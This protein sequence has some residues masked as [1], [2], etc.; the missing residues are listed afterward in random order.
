MLRLT[1]FTRSFGVMLLLSL[2]GVFGCGGGR[3]PADI[4]EGVWAGS[5]KGDSSST[6]L[7]DLRGTPPD[8]LVGT[9][10]V[11]RGRAMDSELAITRASYHAPDL[12]MFIASTNV[13]Y[14]GRV[15]TSR[16]RVEG[17]LMY[18][19]Q[20]GPDMELR[21][22]DPARIPGFAALPGDAP[23]VY[24]EPTDSL[25]EWQTATPEDAG[26]NRSAVEA[27]VNAVAHD[28][29]GLIHSL[30]IV[31]HGKLVLDEYFH[32]YGPDYRHRLASTTK[33][34]ASLLVGA[35]ID[36]GLIAGVDAP[37]LQLL[38][39]PA[40]AAGS[41]WSKE[42]LGDL[43]TMTMG[44]DWTTQE[45]DNTHG[46]GP[47][48]FQKVLA[49]K[50]VKTPGT[51]W[52]YV[53]A[54]VDL[55]AGVIFNATG[56]HAEAFAQEALFSPLGIPTYDWEYGKIDGYNLLDGSLSLRPRD[57]AKIGAMVAAGGRWDGQQVISE[58]WIKESTRTRIA[59]GQPVLG[60]YGYLWWTGE[61]PSGSGTQ[62]I[63]V[64]NGMGSQFIIIFPKLD[65][66]IVTTGGNDNNGRHL[67]IGKVLSTTLLP[68]M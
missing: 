44:L 21:W 29:A 53:S 39:Q 30:L 55:L 42:T 10:H 68:S 37:L 33:S 36:R 7:F 31:R 52:A 6:F 4:T 49:R 48:F 62:P 15:N 35:A 16:G 11:M 23:Y 3:A 1:C 65:M 14:K 58:A 51:E 9:V 59:T 67:D 28:E 66:V 12:E 64:A 19:T 27:L 50:V 47:D 57:L 20:P 2:V 61:A 32:G 46:T 26:M 8:S 56:R 40:A 43:L 34:I 5:V 18:G 41:S 63:I 13:T 25:G 60:G 45:A 22:T 17:G 54:N 38:N 24:R